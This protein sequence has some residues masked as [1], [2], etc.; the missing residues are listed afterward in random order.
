VQITTTG[1]E[2]VLESSKPSD[3]CEAESRIKQLVIEKLVGLGRTVQVKSNGLEKVDDDVEM[4]QE[5]MDKQQQQ[6]D[7]SVEEETSSEEND[8]NGHTRPEAKEER[9]RKGN[10]RKDAR[11]IEKKQQ[12]RTGSQSEQHRDLA[13]GSRHQKR[14]TSSE[15]Y[16]PDSDNSRDNIASVKTEPRTADDAAQES[17]R[18]APGMHATTGDE[19]SGESRR[20][21]PVKDQEE[22]LHDDVRE[23]SVSHVNHDIS[24]SSGKRQEKYQIKEPLW[25]Y[26]LFIDPQS[27]WDKKFTVFFDKQQS[28]GMVELTGSAAD[29]DSLKTFCDGSRLRR[30]VRT[31]MQR[32][33]LQ[34]VSGFL[35]E[36]RKLSSGKVLVR[37]AD[38]RQ[39]KYCE[40]IGKK[41]DVSELQNSVDIHYP[42]LSDAKNT[43]EDEQPK[44]RTEFASTANQARTDMSYRSNPHVTRGTKP[45]SEDG[46]QFCTP[47]SSLIVK[48]ITG[49]LLKQRCEILV[50]PSNSYLGHKA[51]LSRLLVEAAGYEME[52][53][54][55]EFLYKYRV[56]QTSHVLDTT[57]GEMRSPVRRIFHACGPNM[58]E[59]DLNSCAELLE[60]TF[61]NCFVV[62][63]EK[64]HARSIAVPAISSGLSDLLMPF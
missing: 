20:A 26:I 12:H 32:V 62:A 48:V 8:E 18:G 54:C 31:E 2:V 3:L 14:R 55:R 23:T 1:E 52:R 36:L 37:L 51:G 35:D 64:Q 42:G 63:N 17:D 43:A 46:F 30:A 27:Q 5:M 56:L 44:A 47:M 24:T 33:P 60:Q 9:R 15:S 25:S 4:D 40:L 6:K 45:K 7:A 58:R 28:A 61:L 21:A 16:E 29:I 41:V 50:N 22:Q 11:R 38:D 34:H 59:T 49:D 57:A 10:D 13:L 53:E 19:E 39:H